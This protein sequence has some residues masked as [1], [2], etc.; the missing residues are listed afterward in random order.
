VDST[1]STKGEAGSITV[2]AVAPFHNPHITCVYDCLAE[3]SDLRVSRACLH[4]L[5]P[6]RL[7]LGWPELP[8]SSPYLQPWRRR[9]DRLAYWRAVA[10]C[11]LVIFP[12]FQHFRTLPLHHWVRRLTGRPT[13]LWSEAFLEHHRRPAWKRVAQ[14]LLRLPCDWPGMHLLCVGGA[15]AAQDYRA[16]GAHRWT[17]WRFAFAVEPVA[18]A[19][20]HDERA[21]G[22][23]ALLYVGALS[24]RKRVDLLLEALARPD[25]ARREWTMT[26]VGAGDQRETLEAQALAAGLGGRVVFA[27][28]VPREDLR[29]FYEAADVLVLP[30]RFE[31]WGAVVNEAMEHALAVVCS[32]TVGAGMLVEPGSTGLLF[33]NQS[34][35]DLERRLKELLDRPERARAM[36][37]AGR[38]RIEAYRPQASS[39]RLAELCLGIA[40]RRPMPEFD[41]GLCSRI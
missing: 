11:D 34:R 32:E 19:P 37:R 39:D 7:E 14:T 2:L 35:D 18:E 6:A 9:G 8:A 21:G 23:L 30:S 4:P 31:G 12:G 40:D 28:A 3:R 27:G 33:A 20:R 36:G 24:A 29:R 13:L 38:R 10:G 22:P 16:T 41:Q 1:D 15:R 25:L 5:S 17:C 26:L